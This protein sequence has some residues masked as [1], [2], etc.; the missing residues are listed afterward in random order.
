MGR[1]GGELLFIK[2]FFFKLIKP[3]KSNRV[4]KR[5]M[6]FSYEAAKFKPECKQISANHL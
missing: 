3:P 6:K 2:I 4:F 1:D 5:F